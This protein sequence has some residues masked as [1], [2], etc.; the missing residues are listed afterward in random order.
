MRQ[1]ESDMKTRVRVHGADED[2]KTGN[3]VWGEFIHFTARPVEGRPDPHLHAHCYAFNATYDPVEEKW[4]AGQFGDIKRDAEYYEAAFHARLAKKVGELGYAVGRSGDW[5]EIMGLSRETLEKFSQRTEKIEAA[6]KEGAINDAASKDKLASLTREKKVKT[7]MSD[8]KREWADC[9][10]PEEKRSLASLLGQQQNQVI[11]ARGSMDYALAHCHERASVVTDKALMTEALWH[12]VGKVDVA[13]VERQLLR[14]DIL[15]QEM[16][17]QRW[18]TT[19]EVLREEWENIGFVKRSYGQCLPLN[20]KPYTFQIKQLGQ[21]QMDAVRHVMTSPDRVMATRGPAGAG[22]TTMMQEAVA[23]IE[24]GGHRVFTFAPSAESS[25]GTLRKEGF[26]D[27]Q[28]V[29]HLLKNESLHPQ[30]REQVL[31]IDEAGLLSA[32][33]MRGIFQLAERQDCR[34]ILSGD[35]AQHTSVE[36]GDALRLLETY[37]GLKAA[38]LTEIRRQKSEQ[39]RDAVRDLAKGDAWR[40]FEKLDQMGVIKELPEDER[41][42]Q[43]ATD[44]ADALA[45]RKTAL[46]VSPTHAE[47][48]RVTAEIREEL[49]KRG[50]LGTDE[51]K[52]TRLINQQWTEAQRSNP[53]NYHSGLIVQFHQNAP[54][55]TRGRKLTVSSVSHDGCVHAQDEHGQQHALPLAQ[56]SRF[57]VY[58]TQ[59][60]PLVPGD[61]IRITQNGFTSDGKHRLNN[62]AVYQLKG[63][64]KTGDLKLTNGWVIDKN[65]GNLAPGYCQTS[66]V[67][68][69]KTVDRVFVAQSGASLGASS[70]EQ[71]YVSVSRARDS[72]TVYTDDKVRL[73][74][75]IQSTGARMTAHELL[76]LPAAKSVLDPFESILREKVVSPCASSQD[77][78]SENG[79]TVEGI[80]H[81]VLPRHSR[82]VKPSIPFEPN[83]PRKGI[84]I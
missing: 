68:Q 2:R 84:S 32:R 55:L 72:V 42:K 30:L 18:C 33:Q 29:A 43:I 82:E 52:L 14:D 74:E 7:S 40:G 38:Q 25:R 11:T 48:E 26:Q 50:K 19:K 9:L 20:I 53:Q 66:H 61:K 31:W 3:M 79:Q 23:G 36:R 65:Y 58:E 1:M 75:A 46:V 5:W 24:A 71:F 45:R 34:V 16:N 15:T 10:T 78:A 35:T 47:G 57:Q 76:K 39:Y 54:G 6:A 62:G 37:A 60:L 8:L 80:Q 27:A 56:S 73:A 12:G 28:T 49:K 77:T 64:T 17:G 63:F 44:Y 83:E 4:K 51:R 41:Y 59:T 22:K 21:D 13:Q 67:A 69:S 70:A 81:S